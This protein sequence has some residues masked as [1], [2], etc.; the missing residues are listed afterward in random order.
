MQR[1][2]RF[3]DPPNEIRAR[4]AADNKK[5]LEIDDGNEIKTDT[6]VRSGQMKSPGTI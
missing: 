1:R 4:I 3:Y 5:E 2:G 6:E